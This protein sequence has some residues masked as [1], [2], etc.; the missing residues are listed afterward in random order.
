M[1]NTHKDHEARITEKTTRKG[2]ERKQ[3]ARKQYDNHRNSLEMW[4]QSSAANRGKAF[5]RVYWDTHT[6]RQES[7]GADGDKAQTQGTSK[8]F[9]MPMARNSCK[10]SH[11]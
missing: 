4:P 6:H 7:Q 2:V 11:S 3:G 1:L 9:S 8:T 5:L 10:C